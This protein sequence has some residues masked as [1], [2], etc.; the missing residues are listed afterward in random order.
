[1]RR[2]IPKSV[3]LGQVMLERIDQLAAASYRTRSAQVCWLVRRALDAPV[4]PPLHDDRCLDDEMRRGEPGGVRLHFPP[5]LVERIEKRVAE[6]GEDFSESV[7]VLITY[8]LAA[9]E[10]AVSQESP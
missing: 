10:R 5:D 9:D 6:L 4:Q 1:M 7:R 3:R 8:G 2:L